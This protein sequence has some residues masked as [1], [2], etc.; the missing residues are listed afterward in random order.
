MADNDHHDRDPLLSLR[1]AVLLLLSLLAGA[2]AGVLTVL[3]G[4][5]VAYGVLIG[6]GTTAAAIKFFD[7]LIN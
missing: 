4:G 7:W 1:T 6:A 5:H 2:G 3:A